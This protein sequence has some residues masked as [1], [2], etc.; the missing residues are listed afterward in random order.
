[1]TRKSTKRSITREKLTEQ[2]ETSPDI[3]AKTGERA[4]G[5]RFEREMKEHRLL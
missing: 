5:H 2:R 3:V 4:C 1:L